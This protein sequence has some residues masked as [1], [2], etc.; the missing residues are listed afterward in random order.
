MAIRPRLGKVE[1]PLCSSSLDMTPSPSCRW[2]RLSL[3]ISF[4]RVGA[5][6]DVRS[7]HVVLVPHTA[8]SHGAFAGPYALCLQD[9]VVCVAM[10][11]TVP[12][13]VALADS[14]YK[15][16]ANRPVCAGAVGTR[17]QALDRISYQQTAEE[18]ET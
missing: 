17:Q 4:S 9:K 2:L 15:V 18:K 6:R 16:P 8:C 3:G 13:S 11:T 12:E 14:G 10:A 1:G 5:R 7:P